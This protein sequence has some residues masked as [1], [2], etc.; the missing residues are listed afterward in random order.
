[1]SRVFL[2]ERLA[3]AG[4]EIEVVHLRSAMLRGMLHSSHQH[5]AEPRRISAKATTYF[6]NCPGLGVAWQRLDHIHFKSRIQT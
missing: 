6:V 1:M 4:F 5:E 3:P 2:L